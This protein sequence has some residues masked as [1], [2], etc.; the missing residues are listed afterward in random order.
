MP[1][2]LT[3]SSTNG[4][5][6]ARTQGAQVLTW[7]P[8]GEAPVIWLSPRTKDQVGQAVRGGVPICF[9]WF[10]PG[11]SGDLTPAHGFAR[12][13]DWRL[14]E[15]SIPVTGNDD[16]ASAATDTPVTSAVSFVLT[17][18]DLAP[19]VQETFPHKFEAVYEARFG[20][21][22]EMSLT[23]TNTD[24]VAWD[25]EAALHTYL[26]VGDVRRVRVQ[27]LANTPY[28][29]KV[30]GQDETQQG[31]LVLTGETDRVF[32]S[33]QAVSVVDEAL[34]RTLVIEKSGSANTVVW[35]PWEEKSAGI[36]DMTDDG[37]LTMLCVEAAAVGE[38]AVELEP[39][40]SHTL[41][42]RISVSAPNLKENHG[43]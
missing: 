42:Q 29:D 23:V 39:G 32:S 10:G 2:P 33:A 16:V 26:A 13:T 28:F 27:G 36:A 25:F 9:P 7:A 20:S 6:S 35:N 11:R 4:A 8:T 22:L 15:R 14:W 37:W 41:L 43:R 18:E 5:G 30:T 3:F 12:T 38:N 1:A 24:T 40:Q 21:S 19:S 31:E 17:S 34:N